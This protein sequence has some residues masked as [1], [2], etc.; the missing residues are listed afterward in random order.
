M[1]S[2]P[3]GDTQIVSGLSVSLSTLSGG[4]FL[5]SGFQPLLNPLPPS[6]RGGCVCREH[7]SLSRRLLASPIH[8]SPSLA[9]YIRG[10]ILRRS[11]GTCLSSSPSLATYRTLYSAR[12]RVARCAWRGEGQIEGV[13]PSLGDLWPRDH[14][15]R[16]GREG[17]KSLTENPRAGTLWCE[18]FLSFIEIYLFYLFL[19]FNLRF[20]IGFTDDF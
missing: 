5:L 6:L 3:R 7:Y 1:K 17:E 13:N 12:T 2:N 19:T 10:Q 9:D 11:G 8:P 15:F 4:I 16:A 14:T 18:F 20:L